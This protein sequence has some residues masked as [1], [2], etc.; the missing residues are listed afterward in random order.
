M[1]NIDVD[2]YVHIMWGTVSNPSMNAYPW[3]TY[4]YLTGQLNTGGGVLDSGLIALDISALQPGT[5]YYG[6]I[7]AG[8]NTTTD[9]YTSAQFTCTTSNTGQIYPTAPTKYL[10]SYPTVTGYTTVTMSIQGSVFKASATVSHAMNAACMGDPGWTVTMSDTLQ[11]V[12]S[13][14]NFGAIIEFPQGVLGNV[15]VATGYVPPPLAVDPCAMSISDPAHRWIILRTHQVSATDFP[16]Y[17]FRTGPNWTSKLATIVA[18]TPQTLYAAAQHFSFSLASSSATGIHHIWISNLNLNVAFNSPWSEYIGLSNAEGNANDAATPTSYDV[19]DRVYFTAG[20]PTIYSVAGIYGSVGN[21]VLIRGNYMVGFQ[22]NANIAQGIVITDCSLGPL[23]IENNEIDAAGQGV[24]IETVDTQPTGGGCPALQTIQNV[25]MAHTTIYEPPAWLNPVNAGYGA[26]DGVT[27]GL[28]RNPFEAKYCYYCALTGNW[29]DGSFSGQN[30]GQAILWTGNRNANQNAGSTGETDMEVGNNFVRHTPVFMDAAASSPVTDCCGAPG[31]DTNETERLY[32]HDNVVLDFGRYLYTENGSAGGLESNHFNNYGVQ[33]QTVINNTFGFDNPNCC[34]NAIYYIPVIFSLYNGGPMSGALTFS[35]N[36]VYLSFGVTGN[37][38]TGVIGPLAVCTGG[39][40]TF[41]VAPQATQTSP[42]TVLNTSAV[43]LTGTSATNYAWGNNT[44]ICG[45]LLNGS[46]FPNPD[47][48]YAQCSTI[49]SGMPNT[50]SYP[51]ANTQALREGAGQAG[52]LNLA[53]DDPTLTPTAFNYGGAVGARL[54][55]VTAAMG[56]VDNISVVAGSTAVTVGYNAPDS[57]TCSADVSS[58]GG[59]SWTR[60]TDSGGNRIRTLTFTSLPSSTAVLYRLM[61]YFA[62]SGTG[63]PDR[64]WFGTGVPWD[65]S[66]Q[67]TEGTITTASG[68]SR[69]GTLQFTLPATA[70]KA[71]YAFTQSGQSTVNTTCASSPCAQTLTTGA[72]QQTLTF[73]TAGS[74]TVGTV[75]VNNIFVN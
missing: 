11:T 20:S 32:V 2:S 63:G 42:L 28:F 9:T 4:R 54:Q 56:V 7:F 30:S 51:N 58:N 73:E 69:T 23:T 74:V 60:S 65:H 61:C 10:P 44:V 68:A 39:C 66:N 59:T 12:L 62:Q 43:A 5:V 14:V 55:A 33:Q 72:W 48:T 34:A 24:Y 15:D 46:A 35:N 8:P 71:V 3:N 40:A 6:K 37:A 36:L 16:P 29:I 52:M 75:S 45:A 67:Q 19:L 13:E 57:N 1:A 21:N 41:P 47:L 27:R 50:D 49:F 53:N 38:S 22:R 31:P 70:T 17:G 18:Q 64:P 25:S 26:W